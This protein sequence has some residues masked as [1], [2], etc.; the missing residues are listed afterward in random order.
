VTTPRQS[1]T[2]HPRH[3]E[4]GGERMLLL[5]LRRADRLLHTTESRK[6]PDE[7]SLQVSNE[8]DMLNEDL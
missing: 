8:L 2:E 4:A 3:T 1:L 7:K 6:G 5:R